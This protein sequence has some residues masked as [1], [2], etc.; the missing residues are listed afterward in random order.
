MMSGNAVSSHSGLIPLE[1]CTKKE[2]D[3]F[4]RLRERRI[5]LT[6]VGLLSLPL[7]YV[8]C[9]TLHTLLTFANTCVAWHS[10]G[11]NYSTCLS[12]TMKGRQKVPSS[13]LNIWI[14]NVSWHPTP[15]PVGRRHAFLPHQHEVTQSWKMAPEWPF[16]TNESDC[17]FQ[18]T[19]VE[20]ERV[21]K[22]TWDWLY[23]Y[24][25]ESNCKGILNG[26][27]IHPS[28]CHRGKK[29]YVVQILW[30]GPAD[31]ML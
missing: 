14:Y 23:P 22:R 21:R 12:D 19:F 11:K 9:S 17:S 2:G 10:A 3:C 4:G 20:E 27:R 5:W 13:T 15:T 30:K 7:L 24:H 29:S 26:Y 8:I 1:L 31:V 18:Q 28:G 6:Y 25:W 16:S